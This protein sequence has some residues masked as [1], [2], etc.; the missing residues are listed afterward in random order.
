MTI[1]NN[2]G[3]GFTAGGIPVCFRSLHDVM[4]GRDLCAGVAVTG[5]IVRREDIVRWPFKLI[6]QAVPVMPVTVMIE[7]A[8]AIK[9]FGLPA[10][11]L[12]VWVCVWPG[13]DIAPVLVTARVAAH[14]G[15]C[16]ERLGV[17]HA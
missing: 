1:P 9:Q 7:V 17:V 10:T 14:P 15:R 6:P 11:G 16:Y 12:D 8:R 3:Y 5:E 2:L 13:R 4:T